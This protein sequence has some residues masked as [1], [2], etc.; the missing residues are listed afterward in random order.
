M[1]IPN[2]L[3]FVVVEIASKV[4]ASKNSCPTSIAVHPN[5]GF[6][7][8]AAVEV[9]TSTDIRP[10][11]AVEVRITGLQRCLLEAIEI[12]QI[13]SFDDRNRTVQSQ[14]KSVIGS[15]NC[16]GRLSLQT[17]KVDTVFEK[18]QAF[19]QINGIKLE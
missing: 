12:N 15:T 1:R 3:K 16:L 8:D 5:V 9:Q 6:R 14:A 11:A 2:N 4:H 18:T 7:I 17:E 19:L 13:R 10:L